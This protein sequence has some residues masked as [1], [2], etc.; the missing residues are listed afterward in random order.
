MNY[1]LK[2]YI[3][4]NFDYLVNL[5]NRYIR[6]ITRNHSPVEYYASPYMNL[7]GYP[8][9]EF[10]SFCTLIFNKKFKQRLSIN[11]SK[12]N[13]IFNLSQYLKLFFI[14]FFS[15]Y[16]LSKKI[17]KN[18]VI[19]HGFHD[20]SNFNSTP[21][22]TIKSPPLSYFEKQTVYHDVNLSFIT[23]KSLLNNKKNNI[24]VSFGFLTLFNFLKIHILATKIYVKNK[25]IRKKFLSYSYVDVLYNLAK[26]YGIAQ[27]I[28][29]LDSDSIYLHM[30]ENRGHQLITDYLLLNSSKLIY[31][32]LGITFRLAP[33][34]TMFNY[35]KH[36]FNNQIFFMSEYN[37]NLVKNNFKKLNYTFF[38]NYRIDCNPPKACTNGNTLLIAPLS[39]KITDSLYN[40][41]VKNS[42]FNLKIKLHPYINKDRYD[43][44]HIEH[45]SMQELLHDYETIVYAGVTTA[46][47]E[48]FF[49]GK[50]VYK[51]ESAEF[52][53]IDPLLDYKL[54]KRIRTLTDVFLDA[55]TLDC[56]NNLKEYMLGCHNE[57]LHTILQKVKS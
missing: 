37:Y 36:E 14:Y 47:I 44:K 57:N 51:F 9:D 24:L 45:R 28:E 48:L 43:Q 32:D 56:K 8:S 20:D 11:I 53:D 31:L 39:L 55:N 50:K 16:C 52:L 18:S 13:C 3:E 15:K 25:K 54:I 5:Y 33:N 7:I 6:F 41:I 46:A 38:K 23:L 19:I 2:I 34:F 1:N 12:K 30:W 17:D 42:H 49:S 35:Q 29:K 27:F 21:Y 4:E 10:I 40:L 26:G 22:T